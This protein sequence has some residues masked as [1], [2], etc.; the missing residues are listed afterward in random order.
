MVSKFRNRRTSA[1]SESR[2]SSLSTLPSSLSTLT[3]E[4]YLYC[5]RKLASF[6]SLVQSLSRVWLCDPMDFSTPGLPVNHQLPESTQTQVHWVSDA[7]QPSHPL[8]SPSPPT[9]NPLPLHS[10]S[11]P[12]GMSEKNVLIF[13]FQYFWI[14]LWFCIL[15]TWLVLL[16]HHPVLSVKPVR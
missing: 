8:S 4:D 14:W 16:A 12:L 2:C 13:S 9:F 10:L 15:F 6:A 5:S 7:M 11:T 3:A 1:T